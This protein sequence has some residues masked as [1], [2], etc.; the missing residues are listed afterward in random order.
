MAF[1][2][3]LAL[4]LLFG[5]LLSIVPFTM[6]AE[7]TEGIDCTRFASDQ[8]GDGWSWVQSTS[9]LTITDLTLNIVPTSPAEAY[10]IKLPAG[11]TL[12]TN[13][14]NFINFQL[15]STVTFAW[16]VYAEGDLTIQ[17]NGFLQAN[18]NSYDM[19]CVNA[20]GNITLGN[21]VLLSNALGITFGDTASTART[22]TLQ[23]GTSNVIASY[24][25]AISNSA[26]LTIAG[27]GHLNIS[28]INDVSSEAISAPTIEIAGNSVITIEAAGAGMNTA[29]LNS[30]NAVILV[31]QGTDQ[32]H[33]LLE[34]GI[35]A[36]TYEVKQ[37]MAVTVSSGTTLSLVNGARLNNKGTINNAGTISLSSGAVLENTGT[38][39]NG[40]TLENQGSVIQS[41][42][43]TGNAVTGSGL[44]NSRPPVSQSHI[45]G[46]ASSG[47]SF[48]AGNQ[49]SFTAVGAGMENTN[50]VA[51]DTRWIPTSWQANPSGTWTS[52]P[53]TASFSIAMP[54]T[55]VLQITF[56]QQ[57]YDGTTWVSSSTYQTVNASTFSIVAGTSGGDSSAPAR[58]SVTATASEGGSITPSGKLF[59]AKGQS[60]TFTISED[61]GYQLDKLFVND[62]EVSIPS[63]GLYMLNN[64]RENATINVVFKPIPIIMDPPKTGDATTLWSVLIVACSLLATGTRYITK[65]SR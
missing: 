51:G 39:Q 27:N 40:G 23:N 30:G 35:L 11:A 45:N 43:V 62:V 52:P 22:V 10:G 59:V 21:A 37:D 13:G 2:K 26:P 9:T 4:L 31:K 28:Q 56:M 12:I 64:I 7:R 16:A 53:Y 61:M 14:S 36:D 32:S 3:A 17:G 65:R 18:R 20:K 44:L 57:Q 34:N 8:G 41:G 47:E 63:D 55:Y 46:I 33:T 6:A 49:I 25:D 19:T 15:N 50:P 24:F 1:K 58:I 54:G 38:I 29:P 42:I 60:K 5:L 48:T